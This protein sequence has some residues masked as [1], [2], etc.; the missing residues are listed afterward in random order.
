MALEFYP[1]DLK[2]ELAF[3][4]SRKSSCFGW[5]V[6]LHTVILIV[7]FDLINIV[8]LLKN[9]PWVFSHDMLDLLYILDVL[10]LIQKDL[11]QKRCAMSR[12]GKYLSSFFFSAQRDLDKLRPEIDEDYRLVSTWVKINRMR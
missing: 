12:T 2:Q 7:F 11:V 9:D 8:E 10:F 4:G 5:R 6:G 1:K 3:S